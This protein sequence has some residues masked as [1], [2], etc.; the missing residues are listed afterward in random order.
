MKADN[1]IASCAP[2]RLDVTPRI[3]MPV[4][5]ATPM[6]VV[7]SPS[8]AARSCGATAVNGNVAC[9]EPKR[10][11]PIPATPKASSATVKTG[12]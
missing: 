7:I 6:V 11:W 10:A 12:V 3:T 1:S 2:N 5:S 8:A 4:G 9:V